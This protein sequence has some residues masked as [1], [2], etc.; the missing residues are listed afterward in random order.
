MKN[1]IM[2]K[3]GKIVVFI[4]VAF[5][6]LFVVFLIATLMKGA[7]AAV[8]MSVSGIAISI[9]Y[10]ALF[11]KSKPDEEQNHDKDLTLKK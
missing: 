11:K 1:E 7:V 10:Q 9:L 6:V 3:G 8:V 4:I 2:G 5:V